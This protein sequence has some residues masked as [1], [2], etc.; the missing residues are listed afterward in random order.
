[1]HILG[2]KYWYYQNII[3]FPTGALLCCLGKSK[4]AKKLVAMLQACEVICQVTDTKPV[5][6]P[7]HSTAP[8]E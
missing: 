1:M 2:K 8:T 3:P 5:N 4:Q 7:M 6:K